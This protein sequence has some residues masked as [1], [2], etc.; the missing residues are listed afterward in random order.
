MQVIGDSDRN[1]AHFFKVLFDADANDL[2]F[3]DMVLRTDKLTA[4]MSANLVVEAGR[5]KEIEGSWEVSQSILGKMALAGEIKAAF[6][7]DKYENLQNITVSIPRSGHVHLT[8]Y[9]SSEEEKARA[10]QLVRSIENVEGVVNELTL[11]LFTPPITP[12]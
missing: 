1:R 5:Q 8:G 6:R 7:I 4:E 12:Y 9:V 3:Y 2:A 10:E 11:M